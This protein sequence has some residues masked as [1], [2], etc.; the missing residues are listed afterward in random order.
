MN[1]DIFF[2]LQIYRFQSHVR[3]ECPSIQLSTPN[4]Y[5]FHNHFIDGIDGVQDRE[6]MKTNWIYDRTVWGLNPKYAF[7]FSK[8]TA[9]VLVNQ[10]NTTPP[11]AT[12][13]I[14]I[15]QSKVPSQ[16]SFTD[17][18]VFGFYIY[19]VPDSLLVFMRIDNQTYDLKSLT[20]SDEDHNDDILPHPHNKNTPFYDIVF[21]DKHVFAYMYDKEPIGTS[22][23]SWN[24]ICIPSHNGGFVSLKECIH[25]SIDDM[26]N[27]STFLGDPLTDLS[28][29][30]TPTQNRYTWI[31][32]IIGSV[33]AG[34]LISVLVLSKWRIYRMI[35]NRR[36]TVAINNR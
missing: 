24:Q 18:F 32:V 35:R 10:N 8:A 26:H 2:P 4:E 30:F 25:H 19:P 21:I 12:S 11:F 22:W 6:T 33:I 29:Y 1:Y 13:R 27:R 3:I 7:Y 36:S 9:W 15:A 23:T 17:T 16:I 31:L 14:F 20:I 5:V 28:S 34:L